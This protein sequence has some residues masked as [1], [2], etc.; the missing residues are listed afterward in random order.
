MRQPDGSLQTRYDLVRSRLDRFVDNGL[1]LMIILDDVP[2]AFVD[3]RSEQCQGFGCQYLPPRDPAE[4]ASWV[5][6]LAGFMIKAYGGDYASRIRWRLGTEANGPRWSN[7]GVLFDPFLET[8]SR[9]MKR[10]KEVIPGAEVGASNWVEVTG[11]SGNLTEHGSDAFQW[12]FYSALA[13]DPSIPLDWV[14]E[15]HY[16]SYGNQHAPNF[17]GADY[18]QR[19]PGGTSGAFELEAMRKL[20]QRPKASLEIQEWSILNNEDHNP[21]YYTC[22]RSPA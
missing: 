18:I 12:K 1:D 3:V 21:T 15:S 8:Y 11:A 14:S 6:D 19:T 4:F 20:A 17:P 16:G 10:I 9:T 7:H 22:T 13:A 5:G 2:W